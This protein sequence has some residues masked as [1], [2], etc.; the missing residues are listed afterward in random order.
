M[1][2]D[3]LVSALLAPP[4]V[5][6]VEVAL[7]TGLRLE[8]ITAKLQTLPLSMDPREFY[9]LA[10]SPPAALIDDYPWLKKILADAPKGASL[11]GFLW[12][13]TYRV[14]P[15]TTPEELVRLMLDKFIANV[16]EERLVVP[17]T[18]A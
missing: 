12:P 18:A 17:A 15:D 2:P 11:E 13:A 14:L 8:Q 4:E 16:G 9:E 5:K 10:K 3:Q 1:T 6:F 7:R